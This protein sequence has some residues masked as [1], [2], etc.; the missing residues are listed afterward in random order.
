[1]RGCFTDKLIWTNLIKASARYAR[2]PL[3]VAVNYDDC[4]L[5]GLMSRG[6]TDYGWS[7]CAMCMASPMLAK[8]GFHITCWCVFCLMSVDLTLPTTGLVV[9]WNFVL[10]VRRIYSG[11]FTILRHHRT[12]T[13]NILM[14]VWNC[15]LLPF[16][17]MCLFQRHTIYLLD[18]FWF[19]LSAWHFSI[20]FASCNMDVL[21][22]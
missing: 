14:H 5:Q 9:Y 15:L 13:R 12:F 10:F 18:L 21:I 11:N 7:I 20:H 17:M 19:I 8:H 3:S 2:C 4:L 1:M 16:Q 22:P 6:A